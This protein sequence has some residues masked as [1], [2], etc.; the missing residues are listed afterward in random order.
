MTPTEFKAEFAEFAG[1]SDS[2]VQA[3]LTQAEAETDAAVF[4]AQVDD[5]VKYLAAHLLALSP[6][7]RDM[8]L[9]DKGGETVYGRQRRRLERIY[10]G[11]PYIA[12]DN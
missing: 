1:A 11:G 7:A 9:V 4:G 3:K 8:K 10:A 2:I 12:S 5:A 6:F